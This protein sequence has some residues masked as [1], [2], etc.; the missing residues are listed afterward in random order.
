VDC[1]AAVSCGCRLARPVDTMIRTPRS[2]QDS[3][4]LSTRQNRQIRFDR[5]SPGAGNG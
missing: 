5:L 1:F 4:Q 3:P 2:R